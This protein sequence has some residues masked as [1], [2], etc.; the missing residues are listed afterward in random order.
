MCGIGKWVEMVGGEGG[1]R[2][3]GRAEGWRG[4]GK[5][6]PIPSCLFF[7]L[8]PWGRGITQL[9]AGSL[10]QTHSAICAG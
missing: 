1:G 4:A 10:A 3:E 7:H 2:R 6:W 5:E 8:E 9:V